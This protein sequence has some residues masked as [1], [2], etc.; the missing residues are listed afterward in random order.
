MKCV[1]CTVLIKY[2]FFRV[3]FASSLNFLTVNSV[4]GFE[5]EK[6]VKCFERRNQHFI[7]LYYSVN[8]FLFTLQLNLSEYLTQ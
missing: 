7:V 6:R 5:K 1:T 2:L 4:A 3:D 8:S